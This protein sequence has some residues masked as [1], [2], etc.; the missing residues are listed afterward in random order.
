MKNHE[1]VVLDD[2]AIEDPSMVGL[3]FVGGVFRLKK[4][5]VQ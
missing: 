1:N 3:G 5:E 2:V 4:D